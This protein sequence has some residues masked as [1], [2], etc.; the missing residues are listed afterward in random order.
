MSVSGW[1]GDKAEGTLVLD[2]A[3]YTVLVRDVSRMY[4]LVLNGNPLDFASEIQ[5][6]GSFWQQ[7]FADQNKKTFP[8]TAED[9]NGIYYC[10]HSERQLATWLVETCISLV[11]GENNDGITVE[12]VSKLR[13]KLGMLSAD[14][15]ETTIGMQPPKM[16]KKYATPF[17]SSFC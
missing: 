12:N 13:G 8:A 3:K 1:R 15:R 7:G 16:R 11:L 17:A 9:K 6:S 2:N 5:L 4:G 10:C 14:L